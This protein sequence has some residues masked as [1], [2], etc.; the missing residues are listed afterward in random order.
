MRQL[1]LINGVACFVLFG[2]SWFEAK[3]A[4]TGCC[5]MHDCQ[6][7]CVK[8]QGYFAVL[9]GVLENHNDTRRVREHKEDEEYE[10]YNQ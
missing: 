3:Y 2:P 10:H 5:L 7:Q 1:L 4:P 8:V 9:K 6:L